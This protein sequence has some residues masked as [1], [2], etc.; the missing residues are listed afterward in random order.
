[1]GLSGDLQSPSRLAFDLAR[2]SANYGRFS[3][4]PFEVGV[5]TTIGNALRRSLLNGLEGAA[6]TAVKI[7]GVTHEFGSIPGVVE[8]ANEILL[9]LQKIPFKLDGSGPKTL[10]IFKDRHGQVTSADIE[11]DDEVRILHPKTYIATVNEGGSLSIEMRLKRASGFVSA[12]ENSD[13]DLDI[14]YIPIDSVH[15]PVKAVD[16]KVETVVG[17]Q[18]PFDKLSIEIWTDGSMRPEVALALAAKAVSDQMSIVINFQDDSNGSRLPKMEGN[19]RRELQDRLEELRKNMQRVIADLKSL[20]NEDLIPTVRNV[21]QEE[22]TAHNYVTTRYRELIDRKYLTGLSQSE[23]EELEALTLTL[24]E[25]DKPYYE[26]IV[27]RLRN[28]IEQR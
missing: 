10:K 15:Q 7:E 23:N 2:L 26:A 17:D 21:V 14:S 28:L 12:A 11:A 8:D 3:A 24:E 27:D 25:M 5:G 13:E 19:D 22:S 9:N 6:I 16:Y 18:K 20:P 1:M 4:Q